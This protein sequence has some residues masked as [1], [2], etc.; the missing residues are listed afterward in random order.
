MAALA[1][2][3]LLWE[4]DAEFKLRAHLQRYID[5]L[6]RERGL[7]FADYEALWRWSVN[8]LEAFWQSIVDFFDLRFSTLPTAILASH[9]MPGAR[10]FPDATLN[11]DPVCERD[12]ASSGDKLAR[13]RTAC[14]LARCKAPR[15]GPAARRPR[16]G[17][18]AEYP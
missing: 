7:R 2:G 12:E 15:Y 6:A 10:W 13:A 1:E 9:D 8:D 14:R 11:R 16:C 17:L 18:S 5:W 4:P 3:K